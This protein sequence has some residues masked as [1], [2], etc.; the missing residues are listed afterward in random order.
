MKRFIKIITLC[1]TLAIPTFSFASTWN[2]DTD[3]SNVGF[4]VKHLM[5]SNVKGN[6]EKYSGTVDLDEKDITKLKVNV[7]I[8]T[9]SI[10]TGVQKR[11]EHLKSADFFDATKFPTMTFVSRKTSKSGNGTIKITGDLTI[12]GITRSVVLNAEPISKEILDP[13]G[14]TRRGTTA[15]AKINRKDFGLT[16]NKALE[17]GGVVVGDEISISLDI[18]MVKAQLK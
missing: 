9:T 5:V 12:H 15:N 14:H 10:N 1:L 4:K 18:E 11:D 2:I 17:K 13:W 6:F 3:H 7:T 8:D 16:W